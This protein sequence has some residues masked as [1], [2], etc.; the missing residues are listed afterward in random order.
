MKFGLRTDEK[1]ANN[2]QITGI[3]DKGPDAAHRGRPMAAGK[4]R[5]SA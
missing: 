2:W 5:H 4:G 1:L 3:T